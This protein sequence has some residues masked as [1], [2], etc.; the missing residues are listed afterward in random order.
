LII[1]VSSYITAANRASPVWPAAY[2]SIIAGSAY[3]DDITHAAPVQMR[4]NK[5][6]AINLNPL[7][8]ICI[9]LKPLPSNILQIVQ[10]KSNEV[11]NGDRKETA[12]SP[13]GRE[14]F[15]K[16]AGDCVEQSKAWKQTRSNRDTVCQDRLRTDR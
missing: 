3:V 5:Y 7:E 11:G 14:R 8:C 12:E 15:R 2:C 10:D 13:I 16:I 9:A 1:A 4:N 6:K